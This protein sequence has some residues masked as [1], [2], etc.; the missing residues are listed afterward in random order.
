MRDSITV[1]ALPGDLPSYLEL[2][3]SSLTS[4]DAVL[5]VSDLVVPERVTVVTDGAELLARVQAPRVEEEPVEVEG[6][7][8]APEEGAEDGAAEARTGDSSGSDEG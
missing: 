7:A 2:D 3:I 1:R 6:A 5:H 4:F 8:G